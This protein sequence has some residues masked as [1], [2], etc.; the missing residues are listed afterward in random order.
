[1]YLTFLTFLVLFEHSH[2]AIRNSFDVGQ[3]IG[4]EFVDDDRNELESLYFS[5]Q[6]YFVELLG[7]Q[8]R[9][10]LIASGHLALFR[11]DRFHKRNDLSH[12]DLDINKKSAFLDLV[13][14]LLVKGE[15]EQLENSV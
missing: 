3:Q 11:E 8:S 7:M 14:F 5:E 6:N 12:A 2:D 1:M 10:L 4:V 15:L 13:V 9:Y